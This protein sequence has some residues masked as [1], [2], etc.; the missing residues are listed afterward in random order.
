M[1]LIE[2]LGLTGLG[3]SFIVAIG[4]NLV[5]T[6]GFNSKF[7]SQH[8]DYHYHL[9]T[10]KGTLL[11]FI[12]PNYWDVV[13]NGIFAV[14][15]LIGYIESLIVFPSKTLMENHEKMGWYLFFIGFF[16]VSVGSAY[17]HWRPNNWTLV[18][19]RLPMTFVFMAMHY[20][21][22]R[23]F[24]PD[25]HLSLSGNMLIGGISILI[26]Y[27][28]LYLNKGEINKVQV[29]YLGNNDGTKL[30]RVEAQNIIK[31]VN[32]QLRDQ[33]LPYYIVQFYPLIIQLYMIA[34]WP[35]DAQLKL[36]YII[37]AY[38]LYIIAKI[39]EGLDLVSDKF[40]R[41][42]LRGVISGHS[43]KHLAAGVGMI[44][45]LVYIWNSK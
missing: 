34:N 9:D 13:S 32:P 6:F 18:W 1:L 24:L 45:M 38:V 41:Y 25:S 19:D 20:I 10:R 44:P 22:Q 2:F 37:P 43:L 28:T 36:I 11:G 15:G 27:L 29:N 35:S 8:L 23:N 33:L 14:V 5:L 12:I 17:Y 3:C 30:T 26:W 42:T 4:V 21:A 39:L 16:L 31:Q 7:G 40:Y